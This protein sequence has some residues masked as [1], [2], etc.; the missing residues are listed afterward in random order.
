MIR[1]I[2]LIRNEKGTEVC[3]ELGTNVRRSGTAVN[4]R[5]G[6]GRKRTDQVRNAVESVK[7][8]TYYTLIAKSI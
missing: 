7:S 1:K 8:I 6:T 2:L 5:N 4:G 3:E